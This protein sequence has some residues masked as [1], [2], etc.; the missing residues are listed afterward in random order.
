M[1]NDN[2]HKWLLVTG[3][4][5]IASLFIMNGIGMVFQHRETMAH[6]AAGHVQDQH[7]NWVK[8]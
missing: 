4:A 7:G 6:I 2:G 1:N 3:A 8:P 5:L